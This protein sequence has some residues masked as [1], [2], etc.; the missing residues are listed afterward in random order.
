MKGLDCTTLDLPPY[1][2]FFDSDPNSCMQLLQIAKQM[3]LASATSLK[4][5][6]YIHNYMN[7]GLM[8]ANALA[9]VPASAKDQPVTACH[10]APMPLEEFA[11]QSGLL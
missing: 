7:G 11:T 5:P 3:P 2:H 4:D 10:G 9:A 1:H 8:V 6:L